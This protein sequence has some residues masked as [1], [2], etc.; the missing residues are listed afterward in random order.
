MTNERIYQIAIPVA[1][2]TPVEVLESAARAQADEHGVYG[3]LEYLGASNDFG[4]PDI[5][6]H[7]FQIRTAAQKGDS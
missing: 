1:V 6:V 5:H 2:P 4:D 7:R 3:L